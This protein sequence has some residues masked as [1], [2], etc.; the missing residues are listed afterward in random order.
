MD[1]FQN[2]V[3]HTD[4]NMSVDK[5]MITN[6]DFNMSVDKR[7][8]TNSLLPFGVLLK[9]RN[10]WYLPTTYVAPWKVLFSEVSV[11]LFTVGGACAVHILY[12]RGAEGG[13]HPDLVLP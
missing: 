12:E 1:G 4:F 3:C 8:I 2:P 6:S 9:G 10:L 11:R 13:L 5:R 7:M